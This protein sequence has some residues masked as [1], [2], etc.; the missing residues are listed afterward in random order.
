MADGTSPSPT[1]PAPSAKKREPRELTGFIV[2][3]SGIMVCGFL[4]P[5][6]MYLSY[7]EMRRNPNQ[8]SK[9]GFILGIVGTILLVLSLVA[10]AVAFHYVS[11]QY[12]GANRMIEQMET[13]DLADKL[14]NDF[15][16]ENRRLPDEQEAQQ[17]FSQLGERGEGIDYKPGKHGSFT[18]TQSGA[19]GK[20]GT[21]D[22]LEYPG[23]APL[24]PPG[25]E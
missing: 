22:D 3:L 20:T 21:D 2:S 25:E 9:A 11:E 5:I 7:A 15:A 8:Y 13:A 6:G 24:P 16:A 19:D 4:A 10:V 1:T 18:L 17:L 23:F 12:N 14:V